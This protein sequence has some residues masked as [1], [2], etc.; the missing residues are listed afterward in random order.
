MHG[1]RAVLS[2]A[3]D[4]R[5]MSSAWTMGRHG[6]PSLLMSTFPVATAQAVKLFKTMSQRSRGETP[7]AVALRKSTGENSSV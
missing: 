5:Q 6:V 1:S 4:A 7:Y 3:T 2:A